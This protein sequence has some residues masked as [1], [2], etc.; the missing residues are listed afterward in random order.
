MSKVSEG[1]KR[2]TPYNAIGVIQDLRTVVSGNGFVV[3]RRGNGDCK[4][5]E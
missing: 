3:L 2:T 5:P 1:M 4:T